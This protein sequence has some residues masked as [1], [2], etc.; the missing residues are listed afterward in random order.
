LQPKRPRFVTVRFPDGRLDTFTMKVTPSTQN[1]IPISFPTASFTPV[2]GTT[3][4]LVSLDANN[5]IVNPP[6]PGNVT[7]LNPDAALYD[8][9]RYKL[10]D[11]EG[12]VYVINQATGL[13]TITDLNGNTITFTANG[14]I[15]SAGPS[16][17]FTRDA[18]NRIT[19][20]TDPLGNEIEYAYDFY[21]DLVA[22]T[23][24]EDYTTQFRYNHE[25]G[26]LDIVDPQGVK[27]VRNEYDA[28]G[29]LRLVK[30]AD[31]QTTT[32]THDLAAHREVVTDRLGQT[33]TYEYD[34]RGNVTTIIDPLGHAT[35][36]QYDNQD[37]PLTETR[38]SLPP[39]VSTYD[40]RNNV[41]TRTTPAGRHTIYTYNARSQIETGTDPA[42]RVTIRRYDPKGNLTSI[43]AP[44]NRVTTF[45]PDAQGNVASITDAENRTGHFTY[46]SAGRVTRQ[47]LPDGRIIQYS[48][49]P[50][51]NVTSITPPGRPGHAFTYS[52]RGL[53]Q[54]Y[55]P[56]HPQPPISNPQTTY[57]YNANGQVTQVTRPDGQAVTLSYEPTGQLQTQ[58]LPTGQLV[59]TYD[60]E[61]RQKTVSAPDGVTVTSD[62]DEAGQLQS[63]T[64]TGPVS[65]SVSRT[66]DP[67]G[68]VDTQ[69]VAG[70]QTIVFTYDNDDIVTSAGSLSL[71]PHPQTGLIT[72]TALGVV[73]DQ[74]SYNDADE[75][76]S[77]QATV[78]GTPVFSVTYPQRDNIGRI[79]QKTETLDGV[80]TTYDYEYDATGRLTKVKK[81]GAEI[82]AYAYDANS[83]RLTKTAVGTTTYTYDDQDRLL[84]L[85]FEPG[86]LNTSYTYT[87][88]GELQSKTV[89][90]QTTQ[91]TYD[92][93]GNLLRVDLPGGTVIEYLVDGENRRVGKKING[94]LQQ[95]FLYDG[96]LRPIAELDGSGTMSAQFVYASKTNV[97][98]YVVKNGESYRILSDHLG[99]PRLIIKTTDGAIVQQRDYDEFGSLVMESG[100]PELHPFGFAGGLYDPDTKLTRF[101]ARDYDPDTGR[102]TAKDPIKFQARDLNLYG[103]VFND[104]INQIDPSGEVVASLVSFGA[105][106]S[107]NV[108]LQLI[109]NGGNLE[110]VDWLEAGREG[111]I[112]GLLTFALRPFTYASQVVTHWD[113]PSRLID[114]GYK[115]QPGDW[116]M[117]GGP[118][119]RNFLFS[120]IFLTYQKAVRVVT[121]VPGSALK[122]PSGGEWWKGLIGQRIY[123]P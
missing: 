73:A 55:L 39:T 15:H 82:A 74:R 38:P 9:T 119:V 32:L 72:D 47:T 87:A 77:Y 71:T 8:P 50:N 94:T 42:G 85:N 14:I 31:N 95:G 80:T 84:S 61:G 63:S 46:D 49:D 25:H 57:A 33:T 28:E 78:S 101:G 83:N 30:D 68:R 20:I 35:T 51:G 67:A 92:V 62:Y 24:Q 34:T 89:N 65:G 76:T 100:D 53:E 104:P 12:M 97:P 108:A 103:Y 113:R 122:W 13:E 26:L 121:Q 111:L 27:V 10:T 88:N 2:A 86:T 7:L 37:N 41:L 112:A 116:V 99:S 11:K 105:V 6:Q 59:Y 64:W 107:I 79:R 1:L 52:P 110:D 123:K 36:F 43:E 18:E 98:D 3:S 40:T 109:N 75:L 96:Q 48:Y 29:R 81:N 115:L 19:K 70:G 118:S 114:V 102:W 91:Y 58:T 54:S 90:G 117:V 16:V 69:S 106:F 5:L 22:V 56:P 60:G 21:G 66:Y 120:G 23:D 93:L 45:T 4:T 44:L 17:T